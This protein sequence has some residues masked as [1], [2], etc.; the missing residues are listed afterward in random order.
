MLHD[1]TNYIVVFSPFCN[2]MSLIDCKGCEIFYLRTWEKHFPALRVQKKRLW[3]DVYDLVMSTLDPLHS[4]YIFSWWS[5]CANLS[6]C[7]IIR[8]VS[9]ETH[10]IIDRRLPACRWSNTVG[11]RAK[12]YAFSKPVGCAT[13]MSLPLTNSYD[14]GLCYL[15][16]HVLLLWHS[17]CSAFRQVCVFVHRVSVIGFERHSCV[18]CVCQ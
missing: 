11:R 12:Q 7:S 1:S 18:L 8:A 2:A 4:T 9:G 3:T 5:T 16:K 17:N 13:N 14:Y 10:A 6:R 15:E